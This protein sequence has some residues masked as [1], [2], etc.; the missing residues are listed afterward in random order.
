MIA[1][2]K[3]EIRKLLSVRST[4]I[5][6]AVAL[7]LIGLFAYLGTSSIAYET[8]TCEP[9]GEVLMSRD[10]VDERLQDKTPEEVCG[11]PVSRV[12]EIIRDLPKERLL[13]NLQEAVPIIVTF[14]S[15]ILVLFVAHE[16]RYNL[17]NYTLTISNSRS[18]VLLSKLAVGVSFTTLAVLLAI[19]VNVAATFAAVSIKDLNLPAQDYNWLYILGRHVVYA[20]GYTLL[21]VSVAVLVRNLVFAIVAIFVLPTL[22]GIASFLLSTRDIEPAKVLPYSALDR[23]GNVAA[24]VVNASPDVTEK[25]VSGV[26]PA[27][28]MGALGVFAIYLVALWGITWYLFLRRDVN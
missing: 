26:H 18:K 12:Q 7:A 1:Q 21:A 11:G 15:V 24:D 28:A 13:F 22:E 3:S 6:L 8:V 10:Y 5:L 16:F 25:F 23:F 4:Y 9:T 17:I 19:G 27:T 2:L 14:A 20:L